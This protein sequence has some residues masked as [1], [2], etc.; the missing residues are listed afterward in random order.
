D[1][2]S[3]V[4]R[5]IAHLRRPL[6]HAMAFDLGGLVYVAG[7]RDASGSPLRAVES[8]DASTGVVRNVRGLP[9]PLADAAVA[10]VG[11]EAWLFGG[12][13]NG[14]VADVLVASLAGA[15]ATPTP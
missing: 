4:V 7:G 1:P 3:G 14:A 2:S 5:A 6:S 9:Q 8:I 11:Q 15:G 12:W 13:G 10:V